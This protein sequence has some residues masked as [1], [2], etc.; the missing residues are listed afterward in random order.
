MVFTEQNNTRERVVVDA[1]TYEVTITAARRPRK[2]GTGDNLN[3]MFKIRDDVDQPFKNEAVF[4]IITRD[5]NVPVWFDLKKTEALFFTQKYTIGFN[6]N[7]EFLDTR[8]GVDEFIQYINGK[9]C[10]IEVTKEYDD[11]WGDD[12]NKVKY[13]SYAPSDV[14]KRVV[15][16]DDLDA[17]FNNSPTVGN[18]ASSA[19]KLPF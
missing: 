18:E 1:G 2:D 13:L 7:K 19:N 9:H 11:Y 3:V 14:D 5:K 6:P 8:E 10:K 16:V 17:P 12:T 15:D 4:E